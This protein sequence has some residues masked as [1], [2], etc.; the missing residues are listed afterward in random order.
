MPDLYNKITRLCESK[1]ISGYRMCRDIGIQPSLLTDLKAGRQKSVTAEK[2]RKIADYF[3][4][5]VETL[6]GGED[7][8]QR[9][10]DEDIKF[11]LF[12]GADDVTDEMFE[13][14]KRFAEFVRQRN[15]AKE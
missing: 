13:E 14:V 9:V 7:A 1:G 8:A 4:I 6:L 12:G 10:T 11:A 2:A 3:G 5:S 15:Q